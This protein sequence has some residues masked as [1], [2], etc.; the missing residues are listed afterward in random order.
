MSMHLEAKEGQIAERILVPGDPLRAKYIA[1]KF[2]TDPVQF[3]AV[4]G[5]LG[6]TGTYKGVP[7]SVMGTGMGLPSISIYAT[8]LVRDY[9]VK[10]LIRVGTCGTMQPDKIGLRA[11]V[12]A[13]ACST[14][15]DINTRV[16]PGSYCPCADWD[17]LMRAYEIGK[18]KGL[19]MFV[20]NALSGDAFYEEDDPK[21]NRWQQYGVL[22]AEMEGA[23]LYTIAKKY[24]V[25]ALMEVTVTD[26]VP[27]VPELTA[28]ERQ[29]T[30]D[31]MI[32]LGLDTAIEF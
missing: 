1:E 18:E 31:D 8:E 12:L 13:Q 3:N 9:G 26:G 21:G 16:F 2:L 30:L 19:D 15:S 10:T 5:I 28:M 29:Q 25:R 23:G 11:V 6:Y 27:G 20:G 24:D 22:V 7:V 17:L 14:T 32:T 4:R